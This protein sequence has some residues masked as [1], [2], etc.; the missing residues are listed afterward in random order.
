MRKED[1]RNWTRDMLVNRIIEL[2]DNMECQKNDAELFYQNAR[3][4]INELKAENKALKQHIED[5]DLKSKIDN[6]KLDKEIIRLQDQ[7]QQDCIRISD[8]TTT[9]HVLS[10]LYS[11]LRKTVGMD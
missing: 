9:I 2:E 7:H 6:P 11:T 10:E 4:E 5:L 1:L 8:L 3:R